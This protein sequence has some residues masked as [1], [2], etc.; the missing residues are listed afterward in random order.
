[1]TVAYGL[2]VFLHLSL[3]LFRQAAGQAWEKIG[4]LRRRFLHPE[5]MADLTGF[6]GAQSPVLNH[7]IFLSAW[8][9]L[10]LYSTT[11]HSKEVPYD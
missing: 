2:L 9:I 7:W 3:P 11:A 8:G 10:V 6:P 1:M 5:G 4:D